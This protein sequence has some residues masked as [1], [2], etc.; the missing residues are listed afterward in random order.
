MKTVGRIYEKL[1]EWLA[2]YAAGAAIII[3]ML[4]VS[5]N[6]IARYVFLSPIKGMAYVV[7]LLVVPIAYFPLAYGW[8]SKGTFVAATFLLDKVGAKT[9]WVLELLYQLIALVALAGLIGYA[10]IIQTMWAIDINHRAGAIDFNIVT[11]PF[12]AT[13]IVSCSLLFIRIII[14]LIK[15][16]RGEE[17]TE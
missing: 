17:W 4:Y 1:E 2:L 7:A 12:R 13:M 10:S 6:V 5:A 9:R 14:G 15:H 3:A 8:R 16:M 11:W